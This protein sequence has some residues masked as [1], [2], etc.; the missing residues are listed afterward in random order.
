MSERGV[1]TQ[2]GDVGA[3]TPQTA[4]SGAGPV[5]TMT[6]EVTRKP[7]GERASTGIAGLDEVLHGGLIRG[8]TYLL[9]GP[10]GTGKTTLGWHYLMAGV[11][12]GEPVLFISF[13]ESE[14]TLRTNAA[15]SG[16]DL[17]G[18]SFVDLS[19][20]S[21][22]FSE[23][24]S[25]DLFSASEVEREPTTQKIVEAVEAIEPRRVF[26]D[27]ITHLRYFAADPFEFRRQT[28]SFVRY[29][30]DCGADVLTTSEATKNLPDDDL[31]FLSD[32]VI[33][34][35]PWIPV[36]S[37]TVTKF[38]G[39]EFE[40][41]RHALRLS[42]SGA[43]VFPRLIPERYRKREFD[44]EVLPS[45]LPGL[46]EMLHGGIERGTVTLLTG[47][48][49]VGKTTVGVQFMKEAAGRG[50]RSTV[51]TFDE[52]AATLR[53][54]CQSINI[55]VAQMIERGTLSIVEVEALRFGPDEFAN[56][57]RTDVEHNGTRIVMIDSISG[58][59]LSI[60]GEDLVERLHALCRYLQNVG[61]TV[62]LVN[63]LQELGDFRV[64]EIGI[65]YLADNVLFM[66]YLEWRDERAAELHRVV[67]VLK[68]RLSDFDKKVR[69]FSLTAYGI[70]IGEPIPHLN[71]LLGESHIGRG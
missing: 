38:R 64:T 7:V 70:Q 14:A 13:G 10:P 54:R 40:Q 59:S 67:G 53:K 69:E 61:V 50:D 45:G 24:K 36:K 18:V 28:L 31:R 19:P 5:A 46:D 48:S 16:F 26:I 4:A 62:L 29:L 51:Y 9:T 58:Y 71:G 47:P 11:A 23:V 60:S 22:H 21:K 42:D 37:L 32:G 12:A 8:R 27:S 2:R 17:R 34:L 6:S 20:S 1:R 33:E 55:P 41:G 68:K 3:N 63:E 25:Y 30:V 57:V 49:G 39:S 52:P 43:T 65:T 56:M 35:A 15:L 66:R 44:T